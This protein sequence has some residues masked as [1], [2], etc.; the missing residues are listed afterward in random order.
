MNKKAIQLLKKDMQNYYRQ[1][2]CK[3]NLS[4]IASILQRPAI[5][6]IITY[7]L[8]AALADHKILFLLYTFLLWV[9]VKVITGIEIYPQTKIGEN[10]Y[11]IH[12]GG[13]FICPKAVIGKNCTLLNNVTIGTDFD[14]KDAPEIGNNVKIGAGAKIIG[15]I[16]VGH[17]ALIG[18][19]AT[20]TKNVPAGAVCVGAQIKER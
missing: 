16:K 20:V 17:H 1:L 9:P 13:I 7:R 18:A 8:G 19:N 4:F 10:F 14:G 12:F 6:A 15:K 3:D 5:W 11:I 2:G